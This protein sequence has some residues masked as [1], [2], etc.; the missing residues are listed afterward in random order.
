MGNLRRR[1]E[2]RAL[3]KES[4]EMITIKDFMETVNFRI[5]EG[6][7]YGWNCFGSNAYLLTY[8]NNVNNGHSVCLTFDTITQEVY[9]ME[10]C[11]Y[12]NNRAYRLL[13]PNYR[14][15]YF[16]E[17]KSRNIDDSAWDDV[18]YI[19]LE[20][21]DD[22]L[23]KTRAIVAGEE[24]DTRVSVTLDLNDDDLLNLFKLAHDAD[25]SLND[26]VEKILYDF[27]STGEQS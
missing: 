10:A 16:D 3:I 6:S 14:Q 24:Y 7:N 20:V 4:T 15:A 27:I 21:I 13:N 8:W 12:A 9:S 22:M 2:K 5:S 11:D 25:M 23:E 19:D 17:C 26:F 18:K 1:S